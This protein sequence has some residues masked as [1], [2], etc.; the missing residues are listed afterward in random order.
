MNQWHSIESIECDISGQVNATTP[1]TG[2]Q[3]P[4]I[5]CLTSGAAVIEQLGMSPANMARDA[6]VLVAILVGFR[7]AA[8]TALYIRVKRHR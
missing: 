2:D 7:L 3:V 5:N 8:F 1:A 6:L 4:V